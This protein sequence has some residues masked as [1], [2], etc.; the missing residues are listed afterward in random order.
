[1]KI[2]FHVH[3]D[4]SDDAGAKVRDIIK[5]AESKGLD[6]VVILDH[7]T[8]KWDDASIPS[9]TSLK[10]FR[11]GEYST[12]D[13][14]II[15]IGAKTPIEDICTFKNGRFETSCVIDEARRQEAVLIMAHPFRWLKKP[16][17]DEL[18]LKMD[19]LE[20]YNSRNVLLRNNPNA[21]EKALK[22]AYRLK[23]PTIS[24]SDAHWADEVGTSYVVVDTKGAAFEIRNLSNYTLKVF[25]AP[26]HPV[27]EFRSQWHK[28][29]R[30]KDNKRKLKLIIKLMIES[31]KYM[32]M[33]GSLQSG[34]IHTYEGVGKTDD[35]I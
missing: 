1:M 18:L 25:G 5:T 8:M 4:L 26:S 9:D 29:S 14:H 31:L 15:V 22:A 3:T 10:V 24:G 12:A 13:G 20:V 7:N 6:G 32:F 21:N 28:A 34:L 23:L 16:P 11:A 2:D 27:G 17:S 35:F 33:K 30:Y 19:A